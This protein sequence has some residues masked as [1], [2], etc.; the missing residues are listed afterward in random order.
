MTDNWVERGVISDRVFFMKLLVVIFLC[1]YFHFF[2]LQQILISLW[3]EIFQATAYVQEACLNDHACTCL[4]DNFGIGIGRKHLVLQLAPIY[5]Y[6]YKFVLGFKGFFPIN[7]YIKKEK[8][9]PIPQQAAPS[10]ASYITRNHL[11]NLYS[12]HLSFL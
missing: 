6:L 11:L 2:F 4:G 7:Y 12:F 8:T 3:F 5:L 9:K 1:T 10:A